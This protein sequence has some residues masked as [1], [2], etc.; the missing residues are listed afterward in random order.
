MAFVA[1][2]AAGFLSGA[3]IGSKRHILRKPAGA[4]AA[5]SVT[6]VFVFVLP[7]NGFTAFTSV[8]L[9]C[10]ISVFAAF[11]PVRPKIFAKLCLTALCVTVLAGGIMTAV[12]NISGYFSFGIFAAAAVIAYLALAVM[13][14]YLKRSISG[15]RSVCPVE[16]VYG[17]EAVMLSA[18]VDTGNGFSDP[19]TGSPVIVAE[20]EP[21][22][23]CLPESVRNLFREN[24]QDDLS[25]ILRFVENTPFASRFRL[26]PFSSV[27]RMNGTLVGFKPDS[28]GVYRKGKKNEIKAVVGIYNASLDNCG[29]YN[30]LV[31]PEI[32]INK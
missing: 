3:D 6:L 14:V 26:L 28:A 8:I 2:S 16:I 25:A 23:R 18:L 20:F 17:G 10:A 7:W 9:S 19:L 22:S 29:Q 32:F 15:E 24:L 12:S 1:L 4:A 27:G 11:A 21:L 13:R 30:A 31:P 5:S